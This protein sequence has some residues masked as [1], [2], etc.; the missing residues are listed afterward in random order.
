MRILFTADW[1]LGYTLMGAN[2]QERLGDQ[3]R[4]LGIIA[5]YLEAHDVDVLAIAGDIF[6]AQD[7]GAAHAA[8][9]AMVS[10]LSPALERGL[11]IVGVAGNHDRDYFI[12]T[13]NAWLS[14]AAPAGREPI[15]L[16]T[17][18]DLV[19]LEAAGQH[20][21]F[22]LLPF[23]TAFRYEATSADAGGVA[24]RH[25]EMARL[26]IETMEALRKRAAEMRLPT[27]LLTHVTVT[28]TTVKA[29]RI[30]PRDDVVVPRG[31]F[32]SFEITVIGHI[33]KAERLGGDHFYYVGALDRMD[34]GERDYEPRVLLADI[35]PEGVREVTSLP[36]DPTPFAALT[37]HDEESLA[38]AAASLERREETLVKLTLQVPQGTYTAPLLEQARQLFPRLY[39][40]VE[41]DWTDAEVPPASV[42]GLNPAN[43]EETVRRYLEQQVSDEDERAALMTLV[44]ELRA[45]IAAGVDE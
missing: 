40:N 31:A 11:R 1:H 32:P 19:T 13:A 8:V 21:N 39:G 6:E 2:R 22:V 44:H 29:H 42:D 25:E 9:R 24:Q 37:A 33:H 14:A 18:P 41:H 26:Y 10:S 27:V 3:Q 16:R 7:R 17:R 20:V 4:Q 23:P 43:V 28:G 12:D 45:E 30:A 35:G 34:V 38:A 36:L 15:V 5:R